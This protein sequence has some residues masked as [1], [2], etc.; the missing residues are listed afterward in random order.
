MDVFEAI[1][2]RQSISRV[3][4]DPVP[5]EAIERALSAAVQAPNH[6]RVRPWRFFVIAGAAR[7]RLGDAMARGLARRSPEAPTEVLEVERARALRSPVII[8]LAV[9]KPAD[10]KVVE[11]ENVCA[12]AAA[13][14]NLLLALHAQGLGAMWRT[15]AAAEE[16][17]VKGFLGLAAD[18]HLIGFVYVGYPDGEYLPKERPG[19]EDRTT[20]LS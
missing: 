4:P 18:Q 7:H 2:G 17:L 11:I 13:A 5:R 1:F 14:Q 8:A 12:T 15:G 10:P 6:H 19:F 3:K 20:W 9:D 16:P